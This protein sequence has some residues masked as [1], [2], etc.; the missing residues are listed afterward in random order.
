MTVIFLCA[1]AQGKFT[2]KRD[3]FPLLIAILSGQATED[4]L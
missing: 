1:P 4:K 3:C 2:S